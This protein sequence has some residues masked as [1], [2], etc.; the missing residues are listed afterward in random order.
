MDRVEKL[1]HIFVIVIGVI[2]FGI[3]IAVSYHIII[4]HNDDTSL[5]I[6]IEGAFAAGLIIIGTI[7]VAGS[8]IE[9]LERLN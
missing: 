7:L 5:V 4:E 3:G 6:F 1:G 2:F 8:G 9:L